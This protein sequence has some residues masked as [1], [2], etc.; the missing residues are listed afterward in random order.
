MILEMDAGNSRIKWRLVDLEAGN[1]IVLS[2]AAGT[3]EELRGQLANTAMASATRVRVSSVRG[4][5][6]ARQLTTL[7][8]STW[9]L[10]PEFAVVSRE[11]AGV[12]NSYKDV[13]A[14][15]VDRWLAMLA[16]FAR[17]GAGCCVLDCGSAIT[18]DWVDDTGLHRGGFIVPGLHLMRQSLAG[19]TR[20]LD[21]PFADWEDTVP[22][23][24]TASAIGNGILA[25]VSGFADHC[26]Q[27][28]LKS[29]GNGPRWFLTGGDALTVG[30]HLPW[31]HDVATD[32]VLD[33]LALALP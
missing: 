22:G 33:G 30:R 17:T 28:T 25:M 19:K 11:T 20:A 4:G 5:E 10:T 1:R 16:A 3:L 23:T 29:G 12:T 6:F 24:S 13:S 26:R 7:A 21:I 8:G 27:Q 15:G 31:N 9:Q 2:G 18:F 14:M 32:L